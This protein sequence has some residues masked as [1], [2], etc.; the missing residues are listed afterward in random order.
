MINTAPGKSETCL[1]VIGLQIWHLGQDLRALQTSD[2]QVKHIAY[3][4]THPSD[5]GTTTALLGIESNT[6]EQRG[7]T[8]N[9]ACLLPGRKERK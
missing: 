8:A 4:N 2:K 6:V 7:H 9:L 5:A 1:E 3:S